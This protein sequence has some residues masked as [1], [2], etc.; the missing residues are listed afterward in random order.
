MTW[1]MS[2]TKL[3]TTRPF[4]VPPAPTCSKADIAQEATDKSRVFCKTM[5]L[6]L[7]SQCNIFL[8]APGDAGTPGC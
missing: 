3:S 2:K 8:C 5:G 7:L 1:A 6:Y 4:C